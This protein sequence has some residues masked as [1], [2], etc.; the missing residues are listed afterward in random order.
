MTRCRDIAT[1]RASDALSATSSKSTRPA[2][3]SAS[4]TMNPMA[5]P[6]A[7][8]AG[9]RFLSRDRHL[10]WATIGAAVINFVVSRKYKVDSDLVAS[11]IALSTLASI[12]TTPLLL[13]WIM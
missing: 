6:A 12:I 13:M 1:A 5:K 3:R 9:L 8:R 4:A 7:L 10:R 2:P 11:T